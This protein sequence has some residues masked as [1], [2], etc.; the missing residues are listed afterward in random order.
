MPLFIALFLFFA[1]VGS[2]FFLFQRTRKLDAAFDQFIQQYQLS[3]LIQCPTEVLHPFVYSDLR[4]CVAYEA[5]LFPDEKKGPTWILILGSRQREGAIGG[6]NKIIVDRYVGIYIPSRSIILDDTWLLA[7]QKK[8]AERGDGWSKQTGLPFSAREHG[9][10]GPPE[11]MPIRAI[12][13]Q[14]GGILI[15]WHCLHLA[16]QLTRRRAEFIKTL[17]KPILHSKTHDP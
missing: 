16:E 17:P 9:W 1:V 13:T 3:A 10:F 7:W 15:A 2:L 11:S 4:S 14:E 6:G 8:V 5:P 12:R